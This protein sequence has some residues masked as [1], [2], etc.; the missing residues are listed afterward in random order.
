MNNL[1][2]DWNKPADNILIQ[3]FH[4]FFE[5]KP[6]Y[7]HLI[8]DQAII[9][10]FHNIYQAFEESEY[11]VQWFIDLGQRIRNTTVGTERDQLLIEFKN[12]R[13]IFLLDLPILDFIEE[14]YQPLIKSL[15]NRSL[16]L[17]NAIRF[18]GDEARIMRFEDHH[19][20]YFLTPN[21]A[22]LVDS[23]AAEIGLEKDEINNNMSA[24]EIIEYLK[25]F[26]NTQGVVKHNP[27]YNLFDDLVA[28]EQNTA[29]MEGFAQEY[30]QTIDL[31][32]PDFSIAES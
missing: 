11:S 6:E 27:H 21:L 25:Y 29:M 18:K 14:L 15:S 22:G 2:F 5:V 23:A 16:H 13:D 30:H 17:E 26:K 32:S 10:T 31:I 4:T 24:T 7:Q 20:L 12:A 1:D 9:E 19:I 3:R 28:D 8:T